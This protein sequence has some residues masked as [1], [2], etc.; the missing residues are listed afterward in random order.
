MKAMRRITWNLRWVAGELI[1]LGGVKAD[2][3]GLERDESQVCDET[4]VVAVCA[5]HIS[6]ACKAIFGKSFP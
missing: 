5:K 3:E 1:A 6:D 4:P 2:S